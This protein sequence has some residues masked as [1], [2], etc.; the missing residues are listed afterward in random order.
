[1]KK[2]VVPC[3]LFK[4]AMGA[5]REVKMMAKL[6]TGVLQEIQSRV[7]GAPTSWACRQRCRQSCCAL[8]T[9]RQRSHAKYV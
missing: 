1:M 9:G 7:F 6:S 5:T 3:T 2:Q 4:L 8:P